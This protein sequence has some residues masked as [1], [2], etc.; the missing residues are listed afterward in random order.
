MD[1]IKIVKNG[2]TRSVPEK[3]SRK[4]SERGYKRA[5]ASE[6]KAVKAKPKAKAD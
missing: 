6:V 1:K 4:W 5:D 3:D 2:I